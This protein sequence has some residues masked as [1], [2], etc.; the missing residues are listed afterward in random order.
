MRSGSSICTAWYSRSKSAR[1][2]FMPQKPICGAIEWTTL[3]THRRTAVA[4]RARHT[5]RVPT[6]ARSIARPRQSTQRVSG[7]SSSPSAKSRSAAATS[8]SVSG[9]SGSS[10]SVT[11][12]ATLD[13]ITPTTRVSSSGAAGSTPAR[14]R[15]RATAPSHSSTSVPTWSTR[16]C[17]IP[18]ID[19]SG[20]FA[21]RGIENARWNEPHLTNGASKT[22]IP[23]GEVFVILSSIRRVESI[24]WR[25]CSVSR[26]SRSI[27]TV[28]K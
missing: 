17:R 18:P 15:R 8:P 6:C 1:S 16:R 13:A 23:S 25:S 5:S 21:P 20:W 19:A 24:R 7:T 3:V 4:W 28:G 9:A 11:R 12:R 26:W 2:A 14:S 10:A 27:C 22:T